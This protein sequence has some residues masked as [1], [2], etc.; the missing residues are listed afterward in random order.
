MEWGTRA[1]SE[2]ERS[3]GTELFRDLTPSSMAP[4]SPR[5]TGVCGDGTGRAVPPSRGD[6][7]G[8]ANEEHRTL[9]SGTWS[10]RDAP[11]RRPRIACGP[12]RVRK[13][14]RRLE[15]PRRRSGVRLRPGPDLRGALVGRRVPLALDA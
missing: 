4:R 9:R 6:T 7:G 3:S 10:D 13:H 15:R 5:E 2:L 12:D 11:P 14:E 8:D 1:S